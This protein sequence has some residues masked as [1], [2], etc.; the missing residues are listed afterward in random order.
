MTEKMAEEFLAN[1]HESSR[2]N[3]ETDEIET[4]NDAEKSVK[5]L[6]P[7]TGIISILKLL[8]DTT[9]AI[10]QY[11][12]P[13]KWTVKNVNQLMTDIVFHKNENKKTY[14]LGTVVF[15]EEKGVKNIVDGQQRTISL[16]LTAYALIEL[17]EGNH[18]K[19]KKF[20]QVLNEIEA[21]MKQS[22]SAQNFANTIS[23]ANIYTNYKEIK[24][25]VSQDS[26]TESHI[27]F[28]LHKCEVV[29][30]TLTDISE[31][32]QFFDS[33]NSRGR[34]LNPHDLLKAYHLREFG[35]HDKDQMPA[36]V[37]DWESRESQQLATLF[38][39]Y[40][41][42]I[43]LW[44]KGISNRQ[45][46]TK[47][48]VGLFKGVNLDQPSKYPH[49]EQLRIVHRYVDHYNAQYERKIDDRHIEFPFHIDQTII[50]GR[51]FFEFVQH[52]QKMIGPDG[53]APLKLWLEGK[54]VTLNENA[55]EIVKQIDLYNE[56]ANTGDQRVKLIFNCLL[57]CYIDKFGY[58]EISQAIEKVFIWSYTL[59][60]QSER[61]WF[62]SMDKHVLKANLFLTIRDAVH[63]TEFLKCTLPLLNHAYDVKAK[64]IS[65]RIKNIKAIFEEMNGYE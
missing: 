39:E 10:P 36:S 62:E 13:Y 40:L 1:Q 59:R 25:L 52:Y 42:R 19:Y 54:G 49:T 51:R 24:W 11:Q 5:L 55:T 37:A 28:F 41:Y 23:Q 4:I 64:K 63:P 44:S 16:M 65:I 30:V 60:L 22:I 9:L 48:D 61:I 46:F 14:R 53:M 38:G 6:E 50:N 12:R 29:T 35:D 45:K 27:D 18:S 8:K 47:A 17:K 32:F 34:D 58:A 57:I 20:D 31:A 3:L 33:Q 21:A 26:F 43:R 2:E 7:S 15:H 56:R